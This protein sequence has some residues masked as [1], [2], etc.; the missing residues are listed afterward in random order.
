M[1]SKLK[2]K[3]PNIKE[4]ELMSEHTTFK[5]GGSA[6][7]FFEAKN[8]QD[9]VLALKTA[10]ELNL[11]Y[12]VLGGGS[13]ILFSDN[14]FDGLVIKQSNDNFEIKDEKIFC[15]SGADVQKVLTATLDAG[16]IGWSWAGGLPGT[17]GGAIR[18]N[19]GAYGK[20]M[21]D[22]TELVEVYYQ[23]KV[24]NFSNEQMKFSYRHSIAKNIPCVIIS[25]VLKVQRGDTI[26]DRAEVAAY[27]DHRVKTQPLDYP[28]VGCIFKNIDL[29]K[30]QVDKERVK[31]KLDISEEEWLKATKF[32][33][34]PISFIFDKMNLKGKTM[35]QAQVSEKHG[36]FIINLGLARAEQVVMLM[37]DLKMRA[38]NELGITLEEEIELIGF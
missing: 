15:E 5:I 27:I 38:R 9:L 22:I 34:L 20:G 6:K 28:N 14:G 23:G 31:N 32:N 4:N 8:N 21:S 11:K 7:Y 30:V 2:E 3:L 24:Q 36:A 13:N 18:G 10:D 1:L 17:I 29:R 19:A 12:F 35:G 37:S 25:A 16:L 26:P 33:K